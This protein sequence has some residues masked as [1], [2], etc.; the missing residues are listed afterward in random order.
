MPKC[1]R[2]RL[3][4]R[5]SRITAAEGE[6]LVEALAGTKSELSARMQATG[7]GANEVDAAMDEL[8]Q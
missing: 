7:H 5:I 3:I 6:R 1:R 2:K 4:S 8:L